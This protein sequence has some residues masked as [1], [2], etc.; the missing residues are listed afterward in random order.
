ME[1]E[2]STGITYLRSHQDFWT[3]QPFAGLMRERNPGAA[4]G[5]EDLAGN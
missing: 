5:R 2:R 4:E 1:N 3:A